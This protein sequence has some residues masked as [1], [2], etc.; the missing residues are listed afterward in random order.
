MGWLADQRIINIIIFVILAY[1]LWTNCATRETFDIVTTDENGT[2]A[3]FSEKNNVSFRNSKGANIPIFEIKDEGNDQIT[4]IIHPKIRI[5]NQTDI[6]DNLTV[7]KK[8]VSVGGI[9]TTGNITAGNI[10]AGNITTGNID[11]SGKIDVK[12]G[13][14]S[15]DDMALAPGKRIKLGANHIRDSG[16]RVAI[17]NSITENISTVDYTKLLPR[18]VAIDFRNHDTTLR[19]FGHHSDG[20]DFRGWL[21][22]DAEIRNP[23]YY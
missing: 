13:L 12:K 4:L 11:A 20:R 9:D 15:G 16:G 17:G 2:L 5:N 6:L 1:V 3:R 19:F 21:R 18:E 7:S 23:R 10:T 22:S 14:V 8:M